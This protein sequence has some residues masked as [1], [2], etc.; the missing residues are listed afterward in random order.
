MCTS[1]KKKHGWHPP[2]PMQSGLRT[3]FMNGW[4]RMWM[5]GG[6]L[7]GV[8]ICLMLVCTMYSLP[9]FTGKPR[10]MQHNQSYKWGLAA[11]D[12]KHNTK[13]KKH[14]VTTEY[15]AK[16]QTPKLDG[17]AWKWWWLV[18]RSPVTKPMGSLSGN[19]HSLS[20]FYWW[21]FCQ[22]LEPCS[23]F[24]SSLSLSLCEGWRCYLP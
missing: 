10:T 20:Q 23:I 22:P 18:F 4:I 17:E 9:L 16:Y 15:N 13:A 21:P 8:W 3:R 24:Y 1:C 6:E 2:P 5:P 19:A 11:P 14:V 12:F 7:K